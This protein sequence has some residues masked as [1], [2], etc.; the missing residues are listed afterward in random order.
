MIFKLFGS[1]LLCAS[2]AYIS[3]YVSKFQ[4]AK[5]TVLDSFISLVF[6]IKGQVDCYSRPISEILYSAPREILDN[7]G[8][9]ENMELCEM[10]EKNRIYLSDEGFRLLF[11]F[12]SEFGSTYREE[13]MKRC[14]YYIEA[15]SEERRII[16]EDI[17]KKS[18]I[19]STLAICS[20]LCLLI[21]LW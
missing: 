14:D 8:V 6:Y 20:S 10:V 2:G 11:C 7:C 21:M 9:T 18:R 17:P 3:I 12:A 1:F 16:S 15:L 13:Q 4:K 5:L 19:Y